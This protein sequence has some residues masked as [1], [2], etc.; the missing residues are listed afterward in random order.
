MLLAKNRKAL[1]NNE[2]LEKYLAGIELQGHEVKAIREGKVSFEGSYISVENGQVVLKN[3]YIAPYSK[4]G[5]EPNIE[6]QKRTRRLLLQKKEV[7]D[8]SA[9]V[10]QKGKTA[11]PLS[12]LLKHNLVKLEFAIAKGKKTFDKKNVEKERQIK[13]DIE[14]SMKDFRRGNSL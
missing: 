14:A 8:I 3:L 10:A 9:E 1:F 11:V 5:K 2:V 4:Q 7:K 13:K 12:L 6:D